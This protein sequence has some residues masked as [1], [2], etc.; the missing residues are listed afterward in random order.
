MYY[1]DITIT[2][3]PLKGVQD[4]LLLEIKNNRFIAFA[5]L[6]IRLSKNYKTYQ[7][8][9]HYHYQFVIDARK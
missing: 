2:W 3:I 8:Q 5:G 4:L 1:L 9:K 7:I 6:M